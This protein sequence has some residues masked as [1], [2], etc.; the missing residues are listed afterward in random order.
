MLELCVTSDGSSGSF[1]AFVKRH[2]DD[3][4]DNNG[5]VKGQKDLLFGEED[6][7]SNHSSA[8]LS[9]DHNQADEKEERAKVRLNLLR[10]QYRL[11]MNFMA[12]RHLDH[13]IETMFLMAD[14]EFSHVSSSLLK[15]IAPL[16]TDE[17]LLQFIPPETLSALRR[18]IPGPTS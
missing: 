16:A 3:Q 18:K 9:N 11:H 2:C 15:Q 4:K 7:D 6:S 14:E 5:P 1:D 8:P 10:N 17:M 12:N 13:D